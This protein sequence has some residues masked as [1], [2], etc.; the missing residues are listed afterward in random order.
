MRKLNYEVDVNGKSPEIVANEFL[1]SE[2]YI[3]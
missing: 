3:K 1:V 2:G